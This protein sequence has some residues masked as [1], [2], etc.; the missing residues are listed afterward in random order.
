MTIE[1]TLKYY[2]YSDS[3]NYKEVLDTYNSFLEDGKQSDAQK[4]IGEHGGIIAVIL[5]YN[6]QIG[7]I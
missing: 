7:K 4:L 1:E 5:K 3:V 6:Y 2:N